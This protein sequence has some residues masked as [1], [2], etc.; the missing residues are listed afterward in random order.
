MLKILEKPSALLS[1]TA[2]YCLFVC[3]ISESTRLKRVSAHCQRRKASGEKLAEHWTRRVEREREK[4]VVKEVNAHYCGWECVVMPRKCKHWVDR[5]SEGYMFYPQRSACG[6]SV[7]PGVSRFEVTEGWK[8]LCVGVWLTAATRGRPLP[9]V[10]EILLY[11]PLSGGVIRGSSYPDVRLDLLNPVQVE[12]HVKSSG[13]SRFRQFQETRQ[14]Y[15]TI[16]SKREALHEKE[17]N[18]N[19]E[20]DYRSICSLNMF[21][22]TRHTNKHQTEWV[23]WFLHMIQSHYLKHCWLWWN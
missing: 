16:Q 11:L 21:G 19:K 23:V 1:L 10:S 3:L 5:F 14:R 6:G 12:G 8:N 17:T 15:G 2:S 4:E 9:P 20:D 22:H 13:R 7:I 18:S